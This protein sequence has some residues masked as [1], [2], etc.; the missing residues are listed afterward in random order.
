MEL[1]SDDGRTQS[2]PPVALNKDSPRVNFS[3]HFVWTAPSTG[4]PKS[5]ALTMEETLQVAAKLGFKVADR[6]LV[7]DSAHLWTP[8]G[9]RDLIHGECTRYNDF[10]EQLILRFAT[11]CVSY[12]LMLKLESAAAVHAPVMHT[13]MK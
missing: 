9:A 8:H 13:Y 5:N 3:P 4:V 12:G 2:L 1:P 7:R 6:P 10:S 11:E